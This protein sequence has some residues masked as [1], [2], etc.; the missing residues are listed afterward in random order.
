VSHTAYRRARR[1]LWIC[2][3]AAVGLTGAL[4]GLLRAPPGPGTGLAVAVAGIVL[5]GLLAL[6]VRLLL[7]LT[8]QLPP[9]R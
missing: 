9:R 1:A 8:G 7:A 6:A 5:V 4:G 2:V 3:A